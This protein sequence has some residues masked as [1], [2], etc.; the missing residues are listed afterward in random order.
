[1]YMAATDGA[2]GGGG[3]TS[4]APSSGGSQFMV[5]S[6]PNDASPSIPLTSEPS[7][8]GASSG[9]STSDVTQTVAQA[10]LAAL[11][12][13]GQNTSGDTAP[14]VVIPNQANPSGGGSS[15]VVVLV[16]AV[17]GF[18]VWWFIKRRKGA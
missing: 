11:A 15:L 17:L 6:S 2:D 14:Y 8:G 4:Y 5:P 7:S 12:A 3:S 16:V 1:M 9:S 18:G 13:Q 10:Y